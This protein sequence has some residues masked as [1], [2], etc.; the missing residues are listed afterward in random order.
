M[1]RVR[2]VK[3]TSAEIER[4]GVK[5][6][7]NKGRAEVLSMRDSAAVYKEKGMMGRRK[8]REGLHEVG[9]ECCTRPP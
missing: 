2:R 9:I 1:E 3:E 7:E 5:R 8:R 4:G 6:I